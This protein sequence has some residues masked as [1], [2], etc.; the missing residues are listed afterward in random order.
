MDVRRIGLAFY[1]QIADCCAIDCTEEAAP[2]LCHTLA[3]VMYGNGVP[4]S[5]EDA[6]E[7]C[8]LCTNHCVGEFGF[9][10]VDVSKQLAIDLCVTRIDH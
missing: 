2:L 10:Q 1:S 7:L 3:F 5:V 8:I 4:L 6:S 9:A